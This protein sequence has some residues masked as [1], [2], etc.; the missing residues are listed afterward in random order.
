[1]TTRDDIYPR[2]IARYTSGGHNP[3]DAVATLRE[4]ERIFSSVDNI[5]SALL[6]HG[7]SSRAS[8]ERDARALCI[9]RPA[10]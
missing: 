3:G 2:L 1:M 6:Y 8:A 10:N 4:I 7:F 9:S 5:A